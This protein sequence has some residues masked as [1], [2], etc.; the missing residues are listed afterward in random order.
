[1]EW[2]GERKWG[3]TQLELIMATVLCAIFALLCAE[4]HS[5]RSCR[6]E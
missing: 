2:A 6:E 1:M 4:I 5:R 3:A